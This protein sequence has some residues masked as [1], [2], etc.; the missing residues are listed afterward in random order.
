MQVGKPATAFGTIIN[1]GPSVATG[2]AM[3]SMTMIPASFI[4]QTTDPMTNAVIGR[5]NTPVNLPGNNGHQSFVIPGSARQTPP[6][7]G[8]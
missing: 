5:S 2:C 7:C 1:P 3:A 6:R 8:Q 4:Y